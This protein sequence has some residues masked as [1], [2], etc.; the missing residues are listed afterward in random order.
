MLA[1]FYTVYIFFSLSPLPPHPIPPVLIVHGLVGRFCIWPLLDGVAVFH[2]RGRSWHISSSFSP[3][4]NV[5]GLAVVFLPPGRVGGENGDARK[6]L[7]FASTNPRTKPVGSN[8]RARLGH[9]GYISFASTPFSLQMYDFVSF[10]IFSSLSRSLFSSQYSRLLSF[11][12]TAWHRR[13]ETVP[14]SIGLLEEV[15]FILGFYR[16]V[17]SVAPLHGAPFSS[18]GICP[19]SFVR[20][21]HLRW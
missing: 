20:V 6:Y 5:E 2:F 17:C 4:S 21:F 3:R 16:T 9:Y 19:L 18:E 11:S 1:V 12:H 14:W 10:F 8:A 7:T 13:F 15:R